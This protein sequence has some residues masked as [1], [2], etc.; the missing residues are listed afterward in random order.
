VTNHV[1]SKLEQEFKDQTRISVNPR[2]GVL[3][4]GQITNCDL[5]NLHEE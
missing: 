4:P 3:P 2:I 5:V 1:S